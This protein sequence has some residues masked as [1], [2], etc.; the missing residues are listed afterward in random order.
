MVGDGKIEEESVHQLLDFGDVP[1]GTSIS[2]TFLVKNMSSVNASV[3]ISH[4]ISGTVAMDKV[5]VCK[6]RQPLIKPHSSINVKVG[7]DSEFVMQ[8]LLYISTNFHC[9]NCYA[10]L[11]FLYG[12]LKSFV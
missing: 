4:Q 10:K 2:K 5:F 7:P 6:K 3:S 12:A 9:G 8:V 11:E 1:I